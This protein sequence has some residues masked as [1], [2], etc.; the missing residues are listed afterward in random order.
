MRTRD[1]KIERLRSLPLFAGARVRELRAIAAVADVTTASAGRVIV[2]ADSRALET[3]V[4][5]AGEVDVVVRGSIVATLGTGELVGE[6][7]VLDGEPRSADVVA[8]TDVTL[9]AIH[10]TA[11]LG[12]IE[13]SHALRLAL[14]RQLAERLRRM[15]L[16]ELALA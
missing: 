9:L 10:A 13:T 7:A 3:Y 14:L 1:E 2:R 12:L 5:L 11:L 15:D 4:V 16:A 6:L 8:A